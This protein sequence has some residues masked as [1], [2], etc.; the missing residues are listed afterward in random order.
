MTAD[1]ALLSRAELEI[2]EVLWQEGDMTAGQLAAH[3][4]G[5][6]GWNRNTTYTV[7]KKCVDKGFIQ[8][9]EPRFGCHVLLTREEVRRSMLRAMTDA[10]YDGDATALLADLQRAMPQ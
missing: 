4:K 3:F 9:T 5:L 8:R 1:L 10:L 7:I 2:L 6:T